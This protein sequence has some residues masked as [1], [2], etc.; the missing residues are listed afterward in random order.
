V[1]NVIAAILA[2]AGDARKSDFDPGLT[3]RRSAGYDGC[4]VL[5]S[6]EPMNREIF[7]KPSADSP[8]LGDT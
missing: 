3:E 7:P 6:G 1:W 2:A 4:V 5:L 8:R